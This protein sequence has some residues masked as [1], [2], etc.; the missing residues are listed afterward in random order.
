MLRALAH[1]NFRLFFFGQG[2]SLIGTWMQQVATTWLVYELEHS[3]FLLGLVG[4][5]SQIPTFLVTPLAGVFTDRWNRH[6]ALMVTQSLA[7]LQAATLTLLTLFERI[8]VSNLLA[9]SFSLGLVNAFDI[10]LRQAFLTEMVGKPEDR[11]NAIA[12]NSSLFNG[13]R[14]VGPALAGLLIAATGEWF[15]FLLNAISYLA[16]LIALSLIRVAPREQRSEHPSVLAGLKEGLGYAFRFPPIRAILSLVALVGFSVIPVS[17]LLPIFATQSFGGGANTLGLLTAAQGVGSLVGALYLASRRTVLGLG[18]RIAAAAV[19]VGIGILG[20]SWACDFW[21]GAAMLLLTGFGIMVQMAACN[22]ILQT[23]VDEDKRGRVMS[24]HA[25]AFMGTAPLGS[26]AAGALADRIGSPAT[27]R[28]GGAACVL[29][30]LLFLRQLT[31]L[32]EHIRPIYVRA[33]I[34]PEI[35]DGMETANELA[36]PRRG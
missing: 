20:F 18:K 32:R 34:L 19:I 12:L 29:G 28:I 13:A 5:A 30:G 3:T 15:C 21:T 7:L 4:F 35:A 31:Q 9:L 27:V 24:L 17:V 16:V 23:I 26:L 36:S 33:G 22:T 10:P 6:R 8:N 2:V 14:L 1:R 11:A 25:M